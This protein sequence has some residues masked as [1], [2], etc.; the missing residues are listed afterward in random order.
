M[1]NAYGTVPAVATVVP[2]IADLE[3]R[4]AEEVLAFLVERHGRR[5][6]LACSF[7]KEATVLVDLL[8]GIDPGA[9]VF[10][11]DTGVLFPETYATW[12]AVEERYGITVEAYRGPTLEEQARLH[13]D[14]L[15]AREPDRCC[16]LRKVAPLERALDGAEVWVSGLRREQ[17]PE[18]AATPKLAWDARH[19]LLKANPLADWTEDDV[20]RHV[21]DRDLPYNVLH[22]QGY[23]SIGCT[24]CTRPGAGRSGR[25]S[26]FAKTECGL[27]GR[28]TATRS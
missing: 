24:H 2:H 26:S 1:K 21:R 7:Q 10:T 12:R 11:L 22:D 9:R 16:G 23:A 14:A 5:L 20:W 17:S 3:D 27:H 13:G 25:W 19:G 18:R 15:W 28:P 6:V 4:S 8:L